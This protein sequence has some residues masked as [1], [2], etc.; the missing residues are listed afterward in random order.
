MMDEVKE[1][2]IRVFHLHV[3]H[4]SKVDCPLLRWR[5]QEEHLGPS[6]GWGRLFLEP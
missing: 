6:G 2:G 5:R 1:R 3:R 4:L